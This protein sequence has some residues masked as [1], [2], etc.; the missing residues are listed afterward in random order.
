MP[1]YTMHVARLSYLLAVL[2]CLT[3]VA[4]AS[5]SNSS[6]YVVA[7]DGDPCPNSH[8]LAENSLTTQGKPLCSP[9]IL[10]FAFLK[11]NTFWTKVL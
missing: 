3:A 9:T 7:P 5:C 8:P 1:S 11:V 2:S 10:C 4:V 6:Y